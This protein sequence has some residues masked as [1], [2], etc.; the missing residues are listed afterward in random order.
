MELRQLRHF[1]EV[2]RRGSINTAAAA[3]G[4]TQPGMTRSIK[5]LEDHFGCALLERS[6]RGVTPTAMGRKVFEHA[7]FVTNETSRVAAEVTAMR[8]GDLGHVAVGVSNNLSGHYLPAAVAQIVRERPLVTVALQDGYFEDLTPQLR[9]G[10]L[11]F[12]FTIFPA[13][14]AEPDLSYE[15]LMEVKS[16]IYGRT[17]HPLARAPATRAAL[18]AAKWVFADQMHVTRF[19]DRFFAQHDVPVPASTVTAKSLETILAL[20][21]ETDLLAVLPEYIAER[22]VAAK[23]LARVPFAEGVVVN[24]VGLV[25]IPGRRLSGAPA[26]LAKCIRRVCGAADEDTART[27]PRSGS[28][29]ASP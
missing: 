23:R 7:L 29:A 12:V 25:T 4:I 11:D 2:V 16:Q 24:K 14:Y 5:K 17:G 27:T 10:E 19:K 13:Y 20:L 3:L 22:E 21:P 26:E 18:A 6:A 8:R 28:S 15:P 9:S 1:I